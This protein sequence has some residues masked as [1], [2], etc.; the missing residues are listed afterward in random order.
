MGELKEI[1]EKLEGMEK[2]LNKLEGKEENLSN[3]KFTNTVSPDE[4][5]SNTM[6]FVGRFATSDG[7]VSSKFGHYRFDINSLYECNS[8]EM[9]RVIDAFSS[10]E[11]INIIKELMTRNMSAK[12]LMEKLK[13]QTTG[14]LYHH[15]S[16]LEKIGVLRKDGD[17]YHINARYVGCIVLIAVGVAQIL[18]KN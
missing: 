4:M 8:F 3:V 6:A 1:L 15:L 14:K 17:I 16:F 7:K 9:A 13:F 18:N 10:E 2:R 5:D 12:E 11:R